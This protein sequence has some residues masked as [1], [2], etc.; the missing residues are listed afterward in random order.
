MAAN[1]KNKVGVAAATAVGLG[2]I[3][4]AGIFVLSGTVIA[5]SGADALFAFVLIGIVVIILA[6]EL[7]EL[8]SLMPNVKGAAYS[9]IYKAFGS[10]LGFISGLLRYMALAVA[11]SVIALGFGSYLSNFIFGSTLGSYPILFAILLIAV[12][13]AVNMLGV[14]KAAQADLGLVIIKISVLAVFI[15]F[16]VFVALSRP[17]GFPALSFNVSRGAFGGIFAASVGVLFAYSGA[18]AISSITNDIKGGSRGYIKAIMSA[19]FISIIIYVLVV[20]SMLLLVP[21]SSYTALLKADPLSYA[22]GHSNAPSWL[23]L[24]TD[25]GALVA[26]ASATV[27]MILGASRSLYQMSDDKLLPKFFRKYSK[28]RDAASNGILISAVI[29]IVMLFSG[30]IYFIASISNF[31]LMFSYLLLGFAVIHFRRL[32][33]KSPFR[34]PLYPYLPIIGTIIV[35]ALFT[36]LS[37]QVLAI[38]VIVTLVLLIVYYSM[39]EIREKKIIRIRLFD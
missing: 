17:G 28:K 18:Q 23:L 36:G 20:F 39:R 10:E 7:G 21:S 11:I 37:Q 34:M 33:F 26:T 30:N 35:L 2:A 3:I 31:G 5:L 1:D 13:S 9:Y 24:L 8:G 19:V 38:G 4:G 22:L 32:G 29:A 27:A 15:A 12:L 25:F 6:L 14:K 16:A